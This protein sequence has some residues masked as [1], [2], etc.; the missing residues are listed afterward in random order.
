M[1]YEGRG[2]GNNSNGLNL[3]FLEP[4]SLENPDR[5]VWNISPR[6]CKIQTLKAGDS[7]GQLVVS[8]VLF[9]ATLTPELQV[10]QISHGIQNLSIP[11]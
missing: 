2:R 5:S 10:V 7:L 1:Y 11:V 8:M 6:M 9:H 4:D 3:A